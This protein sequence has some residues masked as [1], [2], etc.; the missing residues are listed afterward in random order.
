LLTFEVSH[1]LYVDQ[2]LANLC[3]YL[4]AG[5]RYARPQVLP[6]AD[7]RLYRQILIW[8]FAGSGRAKSGHL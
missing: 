4:L 8:A 5:A 2:V 6:N 3:G 7:R 1:R